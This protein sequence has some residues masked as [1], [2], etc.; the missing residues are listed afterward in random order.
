MMWAVCHG[1]VLDMA[2]L[3]DGIQ[4]SAADAPQVQITYAPQVR[5]LLFVERIALCNSRL[6]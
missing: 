5:T 2:S 4:I 1:K 6:Q 3:R